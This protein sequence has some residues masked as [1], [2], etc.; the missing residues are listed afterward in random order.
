MFLRNLN[1]VKELFA[2]LAGTFVGVG[3][4]AFSRI[5][6]AYFI[7]PYYIVSL[8]KTRDLA[9]LGNKAQI[10]CLE[11]E[12]KEPTREKGFNSARLL[13]HSRAKDFLDTL[14]KPRCM[15]LYQNYPVLETLAR[16][17]GWVLLA[18]PA[19]LR[20]RVADRA[21]FKKMAVE[22]HLPIIPGAIYPIDVI[23][24]RDYEYWTGTL[25][26]KYVIQLPDITQGG[27]KGTFFV[28]SASKYR[29][30]QERLIGDSWR[31]VHL[32]SVSIHKFMEG[33]S[34]SMVLCLTS[35]GI[36]FSPL[37]RQLVDL[38]Y[39]KNLSEDGVF[40]GHVWGEEAWSSAVNED[41]RRQSRIIGEYLAS[42]GYRGI[43]GIDFLI[44]ERRE[45]VYP[46]EINPRF[47]GA[48]PM[49]S[50]LCLKNQVIP[51]EAFHILEFLEAPYQV[52]VECLNAGYAK[53]LTGSHVLVFV[54]SDSSNTVVRG[55]ESGLYECGKDGETISFVSGA[56]DYQAIGKEMQFVIADGPPDTQGAALGSSDPLYRLCRLLFS[57][58]ITGDDGPVSQH[59][60]QAIDWV[61]T[62]LM[63]DA[64]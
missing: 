61:R 31:G 44:D 3:M 19:D 62:R 4:T 55:L 47:T 18:N 7:N 34:A 36:L 63:S 13:N 21:F 43:M 53:P 64:S 9:L 41:A 33:V 25:G 37:Q 30:I 48:F 58:P 49:F 5:V 46:L 56:I 59:A 11:D 22:L 51:L 10:F 29:Q 57:Y 20:I 54:C 1:D 16:K 23:N 15:L 32:H 52:D 26:P 2:S 45:R 28:N 8:K 39:C 35:Q 14:P 24:G 40:C 12:T 42:Q 50:L 38:P 17:E 27:G 60:V 6:P